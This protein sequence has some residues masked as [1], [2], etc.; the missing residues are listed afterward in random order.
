M[1]SVGYAT[2]QIIPSVRGIGDELRRQLVGPSGDAGGEAGQAAGNGLKDKVKAGAVAAGVAAGALLVAGITEAIQ[3]AGIKSTLQAQLGTSNKVAAAQGKIAGKLYST[4]VS[5]SFQEAADA[6]KAVVSAGLAPPDATNAQLQKIATKAADVATVFGQD[7]GGVTNAVSQ[8]MRTGLAKNSAE[9]FDLITKGFQSGANKADDLLDTVNEYGT[10]FRKAGLTGADA[11]GLINQAIQGGARDADIAADA[12]KEFSIRAVDG[13]ESTKEGFEALGLSAND[14]AAKFAAGGATSKAALDLTLDRLRGMKDPVE[15]SAAAVALFGTQA[16]DL[17]KALYSMD[18]SS[19]A[20]G[21]GSVGGAAQKLGTT[22]RSGPTHEIEVFTRTVKQAFVDVVGGQ[23]LPA[24]ITSVYAT[25]DALR[26]VRDAGQGVVSWLQDMGTWLIPIGI[27]LGGFTLALTAQAAATGGVAAV[28]AVYRAVILSWTLVQNG[29]T[30]AMTAF[31]LVMNA[32]PIILVI[33]AIVAL[34]AALVVAFQRVTWFRAAVMAAWQGIQTAVSFAWNSILRPAFDGI[35][36]GMQAVGAAAMWLWNNAIGP[37]FA[38]IWLAARV[39]LAVVLVAVIT[40][41]YLGMKLLGALALWLWTSAIKPAFDGIAAGALWLWN[42]GIKP[43]F[44]GI[45]WLVR[46]LYTSVISPVSEGVKASWRAVGAA[47]MWLWRN[48][49]LPAFDGIRM[50]IRL[51]WD[52]ARATFTAVR[53]YIFGPLAAVFRWLYDN[54]IKPVW[55]GIKNSIRATWDSGIRPTFDALKRGVSAIGDSFKSGVGYIGRVW[56]GLKSV[57]RRPVQFVIDTV[58][59]N[60]IRKV[61]NA[62]AKVVDLGGLDPVKF[63]SGG[64]VFG[65]GTA[66]SDSIPALLSHGEHVWTA[67]EVQGAGGHGAVQALRARARHGG[68]PGFKDGGIV[69]DIWSGITGAAKTIGGW[70][71]NAWD[72]I[73]NPSEIWDKAIGPVRRTIDS[74]GGTRWASTIAQL[75]IRMIKGLKDKVVSAAKGLLDFGGGDIGGSGVQRWSG[76]VLQALKMVGQPASLLPVVLRRMNQESGGNPRAINLWDS[77]AKAGDPSRG[78]MQ[79]IGSTFAAYAGPLRSRGIYDPLAN[80]YAS[81]RYALSRYGS[82]ASAYNRPGGYDNGG[83]L[84]PGHSNTFNGTGR[85]E[86]VL[87]D[88]QWTAISTLAARGSEPVVVEVH[89]RDEALAGF[90]D[91]RVRKGNHELATTLRARRV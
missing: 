2:I 15:Q 44:D 70:T 80:I 74:I 65:A 59:N 75:P 43:A 55:N 78:L 58:Y 77:N 73:T 3:Q 68:L 7:L 1:P 52:G 39:L 40:P 56:D 64:S 85:P 41:I 20:A 8:M 18:P 16:E 17:G 37:A 10:Q 86:A 33:T 60:G 5:G 46:W 31:N 45:A 27:A 83:W 67:A 63:A 28:F 71:G 61:W 19:A 82:L 47:A 79:T 30:L 51:W 49:V 36:A 23:V 22:I 84:M 35:W 54:V 38:G 29:A 26:S 32:N 69:S 72:L 76:V 34:G 48:A 9:A 4:G 62:V 11:I 53:T 81:M 88:P 90:I 24:L 66:T 6:I 21:L 91:V 57:A 25:V 12:I 87:T 13:S 14:M 42:S 89:T 50:V